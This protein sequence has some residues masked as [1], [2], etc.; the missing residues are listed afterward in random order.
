MYSEIVSTR[1][2]ISV[3]E[4]DREY[5]DKA[6][7]RERLRRLVESGDIVEKEGRYFVGRKRFLLFS[8]ILFFAKRILLGR[9]REFE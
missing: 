1:S 2:G 4:L 3:E 7:M 6:L 9:E 8:N 5:D